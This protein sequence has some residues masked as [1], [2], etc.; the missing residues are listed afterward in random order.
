[1]FI[2]AT[3]PH[4]Y[5]RSRRDNQHCC[6]YAP[7]NRID[8]LSGYGSRH[9]SAWRVVERRQNPRR[10]RDEPASFRHRG[11]ALRALFDVRFHTRS[12]IGAQ[13]TVQP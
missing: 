4:H 8:T 5:E 2:G 13:S 3:I 7:H 1:L 10:T 12:F 6:G 11:G 9:Y